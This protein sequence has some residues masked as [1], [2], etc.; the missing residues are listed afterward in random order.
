MGPMAL[1]LHKYQTK[2][3]ESKARFIG[4]ISGIRGGKTTCGAAWLCQK[5][6]EDY[7]KAQEDPKYLLG[8]YLIVAPTNNVLA[9]ATLPK[10][11]EFFPKDWGMWKEQPKHYFQLA[12]NR[13][14]PDGRDSGEPARI[15]VRSMD[16]PN[17]VEGMEAMAI[18]ADEVGFMKD[19]AWVALR[20]RT[21]ITQAPILM[22]ST[23]YSMNW[24]FT[25]IYKRWKDGNPDYDV[26]QWGSGENPV[27]PKDELEKARQELP[28][29]LFDR[30]YMGKFTRLE[31]L[32]YPEFEEDTHV[33]KPF[34]IP[35]QGLVFAGAD[36]GYNN[37]NAIVYIWEDPKEHIYYVFKEFYRSKVLLKDIA[38][39][40][41]NVSPAYVLA[42]TQAAQNIAELRRF[43]GIRG[44]KEAD[45]VKDLGIQR[46][47]TLLKEGR[48]KFFEG[49]VPNTIDEIKS[50][51]YAPPKPDGT[52]TE[53]LVD[54]HN[55]A[56]DALRYAFSKNWQGL[57]RNKAHKNYK[58]IL[59]RRMERLAPD[60]P[61][62]GY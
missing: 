10:F 51:H 2:V 36:F 45:K 46:I 54:K 42:D 14:L 32:A 11:K 22:T 5:I 9:Q 25:E 12:W 3:F 6:Y 61:L 15:F 24:F 52:S 20:G 57:Y 44:I 31:G 33:V 1:K 29:E 58:A 4:A 60:N 39:S 13:R 53:K 47:R 41:K 49:R 27:F 34:D 7:Q 59:R 38:N 19:S 26:V 62:T 37:P 40:I 17:A 28:K 35:S 30:R 50:Y 43:Y 21:S 8:D 18:W 23:P 48:L 55:H 16:D 56:M